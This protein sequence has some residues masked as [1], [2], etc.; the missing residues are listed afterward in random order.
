MKDTKL[1]HFPFFARDWL[2]DERVMLM[3]LECQGAY[4]RLLCYQWLEGSIPDSPKKLASLCMT[5]QEHFESEIWPDIGDAF[6]EVA[7]QRLQNPRLEA[8][9]VETEAKVAKA[10]ENG[11][12][13]AAKRWKG[14]DSDPNSPPL[15]TQSDP[16]AIHN[17]IQIQDDDD[18]SSSVSESGQ[19]TQDSAEVYEKLMFNFR[20]G[21]LKA[22]NIVETL[23]TTMKD[24][25][26][27]GLYE[28]AKGT[29]LTCHNMKRFKNP[30]DI[31]EEKKGTETT[32]KR[33]TFAQ[34]E[35]EE[36]AK[37]KAEFEKEKGENDVLRDTEGA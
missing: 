19:L 35:E 24:L 21:H 13:G 32:N 26:D 5:S 23:G 6:N 29:R 20:F 22:M 36:Y 2:T 31:P 1:P 27:W 25:E 28:N 3:T 18:G 9:R 34:M 16:N 4:L 12:K 8:I 17:H 37:K 7:V 15:A 30:R 11:R 33:K 14:A 10:V